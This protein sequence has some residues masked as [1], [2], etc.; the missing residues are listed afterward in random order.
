VI[1]DHGILSSVSH[2]TNGDFTGS[3]TY[4][5]DASNVLENISNI[6]YSNILSGGLKVY[7][8]ASK[9]V[10]GTSGY[11]V[12]TKKTSSETDTYQFD[13]ENRVSVWIVNNNQPYFH[14]YLLTWY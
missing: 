4:T 12:S 3:D 14:K 10:S 13:T 5:L 1:R 6:M 11:N 2:Y 8:N 9:L 7:T